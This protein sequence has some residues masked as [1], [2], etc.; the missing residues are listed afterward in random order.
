MIER[1]QQFIETRYSITPEQIGLYARR[2]LVALPSLGL[3]YWYR[4][5]LSPLIASFCGNAQ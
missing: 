4:Q 1:L 3:Y 2:V 5:G